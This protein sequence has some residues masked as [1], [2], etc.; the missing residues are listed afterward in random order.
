MLHCGNCKRQRASASAAGLASRPRHRKASKSYKVR[1]V[2][3][4]LGSGSGGGVWGV[5][6][7]G[8]SGGEAD[9]G[10][11][12]IVWSKTRKSSVI[13][14]RV[15]EGRR[16]PAGRLKIQFLGGGGYGEGRTLES[17]SAHSR[18]Q[19]AR[20]SPIPARGEDSLQS[21]HKCRYCRISN[22]C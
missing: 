3:Q 14:V 2:W 16:G 7:G 13:G 15:F 17:W 8:G 4:G 22:F 6:S 1:R 10:T 5:G 9:G 11:Q 12:K 21:G 18:R 19:S 20:G